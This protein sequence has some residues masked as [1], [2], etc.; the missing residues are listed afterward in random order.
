M[1]NPA[2]R[3]SET[4]RLAVGFADLVGF[5]DWPARSDP[6]ALASL[7]GEFEARAHEVVTDRG[8]GVVKMI[9]DEVMFVAS[10]AAAGCAVATGLVEAAGRL[11]VLSRLR[12]GLAFGDVLTLHGDYYG[13]VVNLAARLVAAADPG[14]VLAVAEIAREVG[15]VRGWR[16]RSVGPKRLKG[17]APV[18]V[19]ELASRTPLAAAQGGHRRRTYY[20][21]GVVDVGSRNGP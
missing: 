16:L 1:A 12:A 18:E 2:D 3:E 19:Y 20:Y 13:P 15:D 8:G 5:T 10:D 21:R 17:L 4:K 11:P 7:V 9:G 6:H 14:V